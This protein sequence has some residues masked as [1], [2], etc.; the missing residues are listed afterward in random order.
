MSWCYIKTNNH[1]PPVEFY[2]D[3]SRRNMY[4]THWR[5]LPWRPAAHNCLQGRRCGQFPARR[6]PSIQFVITKNNQTPA[7]DELQTRQSL[8]LSSMDLST[9]RI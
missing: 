6:P 1:L 5:R 4:L 2:P 3:T 9:S 7:L 8:Y